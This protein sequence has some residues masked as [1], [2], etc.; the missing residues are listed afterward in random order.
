MRKATVDTELTLSTT[1][2]VRD[3]TLRSAERVGESETPIERLR[4]R[5]RRKVA[6]RTVT[7][8]TELTLST[9]ADVRDVTLRSAKRLGEPET[10]LERLRGW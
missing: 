10:P 8:D 3:V 5:R 4:R 6:V 1:A 9:T 7:V 2:D